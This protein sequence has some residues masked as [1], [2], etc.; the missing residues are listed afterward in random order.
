QV[1]AVTCDNAENNTTM[2]KE[3][4]VLVPKF[5]GDRVRVRCFGHVLNLVV[6]VRE[7]IQCVI[8][9]NGLS[10]GHPLAIHEAEA[11]SHRQ[12]DANRLR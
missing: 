8:A 2:L 7:P 11:S 5:R 6:K 9:S 10:A 3:M 12:C 4:H 1:F